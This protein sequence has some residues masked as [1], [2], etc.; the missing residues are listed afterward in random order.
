MM[1]TAPKDYNKPSPWGLYLIIRTKG[2]E[3]MKK[4]SVFM[5]YPLGLEDKPETYYAWVMADS[6]AEA[7]K[8][9]QS[10]ASRDN[11]FEIDPEEFT[12]FL[13]IRGH[14]NSVNTRP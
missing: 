7:V 3:R 12:A 13:V 10:M 5:L 6:A 4:F 2:G 1:K 11:S 8:T 9:A 14:H